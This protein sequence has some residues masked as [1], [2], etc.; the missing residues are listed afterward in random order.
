MGHEFIM[1]GLANLSTEFSDEVLHW[2][3]SDL[4]KKVFVFSADQSDYLCYSKQIL[5]KFSPCCNFDIFSRLEQI[6]CSW[7]EDSKKMIRTYQYRLETNRTH[8]YEPVYYAYWGHFQKA[9]LPYMDYSRLSGYSKALISLLNRNHWIHSPHFYSGF[10][11]G[12]AKFV[13]SPIDGHTERLSDKAWLQ[14]ISTP[15]EKMGANW[16]DSDNGSNYVEATHWSF[17]SSLGTQAKRQPERFTQISLHFPEDCYEGY[18]SN[19]LYALSDEASS[20]SVSVERMSKLIR[21][22]GNDANQNVAIAV[23]RVIKN[24]ANEV[25]PDDILKLISGIAINHPEPKAHKNTVTSNLDPEHNL[26]H[27]LLDNSINCARGCALNAISSLL[28]ENKETCTYQ[29]QMI[30]R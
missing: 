3:L 27:S 6:I 2:L 19:V 22:F 5:Q 18:I 20:Q 12:A 4:D 13:I 29:V 21:R 23:T 28:W 10:T 16:K 30:C 24:H 26:A 14:I 8:K 25:W 9:L 15:Q 1:H 17:A 11:G 7:K